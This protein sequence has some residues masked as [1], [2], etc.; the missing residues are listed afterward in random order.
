MKIFALGKD[1]YWLTVLKNLE[2]NVSLKTI[3]CL[4]KLPACLD[5]LPEVETNAIILLDASG[6]ANIKEGVR[7]LRNRGWR[8]VVVVAADPS[9]NEATVM[10]RNKLAHDYWV[11]TYD[12][13]PIVNRLEDC[14]E[15]I[16]KDS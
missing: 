11:K 4:G 10:F 1:K 13:H 7:V 3:H 14:L 16:R 6:Q 8:Y 9:A 5:A 15:E 12:I 2:L